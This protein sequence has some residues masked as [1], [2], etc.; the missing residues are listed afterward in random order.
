MRST[1]YLAAVLVAATTGLW[2]ATALAQ[3]RSTD[4]SDARVAELL[5]LVAG[6]AGQQPPVPGTAASKNVSGETQSALPV[7]LTI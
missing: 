4:V 6:K 1:V 5:R 2:P 3:S 7:V